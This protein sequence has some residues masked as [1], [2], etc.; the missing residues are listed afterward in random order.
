MQQLFARYD[1]LRVAGQISQHIELAT[2]QFQR[3]LA[4]VC[5][6]RQHIDKQRA[7]GHPGLMPIALIAARH[8]PHPGEQ[9]IDLKGLGQVIVGADL[10]ALEFVFQRI[11]GC[12]HTNGNALTQPAKVAAQIE[13]IDIRQHG[14]QNHRVVVPGAERA[15][16]LDTGADPL[17]FDA[18]ALEAV[19][20]HTGNR[21]IACHQQHTQI[22]ARGHFIAPSWPE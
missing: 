9:F 4:D 13:S 7:E 17:Q 18:M 22:I 20:N 2:R 3:A 8:N 1:L 6:A 15:N 10:E 12:Q 11:A 14:I 5:L 21:R 19:A 16:G